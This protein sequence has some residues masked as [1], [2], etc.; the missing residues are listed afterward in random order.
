MFEIVCQESNRSLKHLDRFRI[1][2]C[3]LAS[4]P[5]RLTATRGLAAFS[6]LALAHEGK[7]AK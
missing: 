1:T 2:K 6:M 7:R 4:V 3:V 5:L